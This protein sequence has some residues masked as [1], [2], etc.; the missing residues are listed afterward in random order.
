MLRFVPLNGN[1]RPGVPLGRRAIWQ[2]GA[3]TPAEAPRNQKPGPREEW[4]I[5]RWKPTPG[6]SD[7]SPSVASRQHPITRRTADAEVP[8][9]GRSALRLRAAPIRGWM[10]SDEADLMP[11]IMFIGTKRVCENRSRLI[12]LPRHLR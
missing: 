4:L 5:L 12:P 3:P 11:G 6:L 9:D 1:P 2:L 7:A 8:G 10:G